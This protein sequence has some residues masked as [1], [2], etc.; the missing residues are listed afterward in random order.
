MVRV[1]RTMVFGAAKRLE[2]LFCYSRRHMNLQ[3][4]QSAQ[5]VFDP[6]AEAFVAQS[7]CPAELTPIDPAL[8]SPF[9]RALLVIDGTVTRFIEAYRGEPL[10]IELLDQHEEKLTAA[11]RWLEASRGD[12]VVHRRVLLRGLH[13]GRSYASAESLLHLQRVAPDLIAELADEPR[14]L[15][16][17]IVDRDLETRRECLWYGVEHGDEMFLTRSYRVIA[18]GLPLMLITERFPFEDQK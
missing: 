3:P 6:I 9:Q 2:R 12:S 8:L 11:N 16:K 5:P 14:G 4:T 18:G 13:T 15:G 7:D 17:V 1:N 10:N